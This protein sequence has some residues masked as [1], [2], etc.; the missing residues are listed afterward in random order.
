MTG[1]PADASV[2]EVFPLRDRVPALL[3]GHAAF[4]ASMLEVAEAI[5]G[6]VG[7]IPCLSNRNLGTDALAESIAGAVADLGLP[8]VLLVDVPGG[9]CFNAARRAMRGREGAHIVAG[10]NLP[11]LLDFLNM[12]DRLPAA[13]L[14]EH[15][16]DRGRRGMR[17]CRGHEGA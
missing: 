9:S 12:R 5:H 11:L 14:V 16:L 1:V 4:A 15:I 3:V 2:G 13:E 10:V 17:A 7:D 8:A 6:P